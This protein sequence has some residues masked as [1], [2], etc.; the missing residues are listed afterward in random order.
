MNQQRNFSFWDRLCLNADQILRALTDNA[1]TTAAPY[2][3][4]EIPELM[5][6]E[7][8]RKQSAALMRINH[9]GEICAQA[10]Y[11]GQAM[12][13]RSPELQ[14]QLQ[15]AALEEGNHLAWCKERLN[16]LHSYTSYLTPLWYA[17]SFCIGLLAGILGDKQ[18]LG[19]IVE[20]ENQ[21]EKHLAGHLDLLPSQDLRSY[22]IIEQMAQDEA[23]HRND[24]MLLG[25]TELPDIVKEA[26]TVTA[27]IM[28]KTA[29]WV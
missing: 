1:K 24:A 7:E 6:D 16:E 27:K 18:S 20:T 3:A 17:G 9:A 11:H 19:F 26:M 12:V 13:S 28:V 10:L 29:Y 14:Q 2:P 25:A 5:L 15:Q 8:Q 22:K 4:K 21:V 23:K